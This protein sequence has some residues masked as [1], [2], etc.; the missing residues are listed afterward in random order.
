MM[1]AVET[2]R[3]IEAAQAA[4]PAWAAKT[5]KERSVVLRCWHTLIAENIDDLAVLLTTE[6]GKPLAEA[7]GEIQSG[8]DY[9][10][11]FAEEAKRVYG[12]VIPNHVADKRLLVIKQPVGVTAAIT[13][14]NFPHSM[15]SRKV[16]PAL[17][18]GCSIIVK[19]AIETT[20]FGAGHG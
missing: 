1:T 15:I 18:A 11:W 12:D 17:A 7:K 6:Q 16:G 5:G 10:E 13:P 4:V 9:L 14:W 3:A 20:L 19:P 8:L 2:R